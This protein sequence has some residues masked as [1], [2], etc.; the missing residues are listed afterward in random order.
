MA[1][2]R[3]RTMQS[4]DPSSGELIEEFAPMSDERVDRLVGDAHRAFAGWR[5]RSFAQRA[6]L[7]R[8]AATVMREDVERLAATITAE[9]GK[10]LA[11]ARA[12]VEK[13]AFCCDHYAEHAEEYL[14]DQ[15][16]PSDSPRSFAAFEPIGVVLAVMPWNFP[17]WQVFR[18]AAPGLMAGNTAVLKHAANVS[19]CALEIED[20]FRRAGFPDNVFRTLLIPGGAVERVIAN[21]LVRAVTLTGSDTTG[22]LVASTAGE[23][24]K[25]TV[26]ELGGSDAFVVLADADLQEAARV[27]AKSRFQNCGQSC[28]A[29]KRFIVVEAVAGE[30]ERLLVEQARALRVGDPRDTTTQMGPMARED[31]RA[32]LEDQV[33][34]AV[35]DGARVATGGRRIGERGWY[36]EPTVLLGCTPQNTAF[37]EETFGPVAAVMRV[38]DEEHAL[39]VAN[40]SPYGL[41]GNL[42]TR[43]VERGVALARRMDTGGVFVNGMTH[44]DPRLPF[45]GVKRSG[46]G[47]ELSSFGIREFVN[48]QT[49]WI[50]DAGTD[51]GGGGAAVE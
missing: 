19:R 11:E 16:M 17:L 23:H 34:R 46:Y 27:G 35:S 6:E 36:Y 15:P 13:C 5:T 10:T 42:W 31:L 26:L 41:G 32:S 33:R 50:G 45:G 7:M 40:D 18:F 1:T 22:S 49:I 3:V 4:I 37:R 8:R 39:E 51:G 30:Y 9:M 24:V 12:E 21:P 48:V 29:A 25:K 28:I 14:R 20:V 38:R 44:S 47:R 2:T 43:D